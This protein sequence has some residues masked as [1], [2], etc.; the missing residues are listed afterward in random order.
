MKHH[1]RYQEHEGEVTYPYLHCTIDHYD[2]T[3]KSGEQYHPD[4]A[5]II[6]YP[7]WASWDAKKQNAVWCTDYGKQKGK[8]Q[9]K[10]L[11]QE[12]TYIKK[13]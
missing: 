12:K 13:H 10:L 5:Y 8:S 2:L 7:T 6:T 3:D 4:L 11:K 9:Q 1:E